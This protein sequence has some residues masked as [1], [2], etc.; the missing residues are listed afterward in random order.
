MDVEARVETKKNLFFLLLVISF[1]IL[2]RE[3]NET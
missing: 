3:E 1:G 2:S